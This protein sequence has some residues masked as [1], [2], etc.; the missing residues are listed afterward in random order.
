MMEFTGSS[1]NF[2]IGF[3]QMWR[4][5]LDSHIWRCVLDSPTCG[6]VYL[7]PTYGDVCLILMCG[8]VYWIFTCGEVYLILPLVGCVL[9]SLR[10]ETV[11]DSPTGGRC[12]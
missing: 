10:V 3:Y 6:E 8:K 4:G 9:D 7:I 5:V 1:V 11:L 2:L 12:T